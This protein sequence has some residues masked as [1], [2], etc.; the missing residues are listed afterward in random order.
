MPEGDF[1]CPMASGLQP[2]EIA[3]MLNGKTGY[4]SEERNAVNL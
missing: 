1:I 4:A 2:R 3:F